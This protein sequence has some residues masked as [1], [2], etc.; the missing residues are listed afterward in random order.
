MTF[1][2]F[3]HRHMV[4]TWIFT[5]IGTPAVACALY[6][7]ADAIQHNYFKVKLTKAQNGK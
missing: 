4:Y 1:W 3:L 5:M 6:T 2:E 7:L